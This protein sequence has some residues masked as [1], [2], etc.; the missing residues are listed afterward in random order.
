MAI[1]WSTVQDVYSANVQEHH[2]DDDFAAVGRF[3]EWEDVKW[4]ESP[5]SGIAL[6]RVAVPWP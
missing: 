1:S 6:S 2:G 4:A 5:L 3:I